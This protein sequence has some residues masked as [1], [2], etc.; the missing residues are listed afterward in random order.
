MM[1]TRAWFSTKIFT[2]VSTSEVLRAN[3]LSSVTIKVS[4]DANL[5]NM[6]QYM[7]RVKSRHISIWGL[8]VI[9]KAV[10]AEKYDGPLY[11]KRSLRSRLSKEFR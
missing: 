9:P 10:D 8:Y 5:S 4:S 2:N 11:S 6:G 3:R 1:I 7:M